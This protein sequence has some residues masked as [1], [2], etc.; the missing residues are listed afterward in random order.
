[1]GGPDRAELDEVL[2]LVAREARAYAGTVDDRPLR[3]ADADERAL[4]L[5]APLPDQG[6]GAV[7]ALRELLEEGLPAAVT[8]SGPRFFHYVIGGATPAAMAAAWLTDA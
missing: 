3:S 7:G 1:M 4:K 6:A 5:S 8:S 2:E